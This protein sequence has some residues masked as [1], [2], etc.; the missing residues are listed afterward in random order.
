MRFAAT[1]PLGSHS[2]FIFPF[3]TPKK[4]QGASEGPLTAQVTSSSL[5]MFSSFFPLSG[6]LFFIST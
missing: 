1:P 6:H 5:P 2:H 4:D 3:S